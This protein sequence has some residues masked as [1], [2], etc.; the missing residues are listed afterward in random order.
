MEHSLHSGPCHQNIDCY[1]YTNVSAYRIVFSLYRAKRVCLVTKYYTPPGPF[2]DQERSSPLL[3]HYKMSATQ[4]TKATEIIGPLTTAFSPAPGCLNQL[5]RYTKTELNCA[6]KS[7]YSPC[8]WLHLGNISDTGC[9]PPG[10]IVADDEEFFY[11]PGACPA[12]YSTACADVVNTGTE[13][14]TI[15]TCCPKCETQLLSSF[16]F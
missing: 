4:S 10:F 9:V 6:G 12:G 3:D 11:S 7:A 2:Y 8:E 5:F 15:A 13:Y 1:W 16:L 14:Q